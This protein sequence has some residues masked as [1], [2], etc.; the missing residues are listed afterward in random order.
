MLRNW[1]SNLTFT[2]PSRRLHSNHTN[3]MPVLRQIR[4]RHRSRFYS[5]TAEVL[6]DRALLTAFIVDTIEDGSLVGDGAVSLREAIV[7]A[8]TNATYLDAPAGDSGLDTITFHPSLNGLTIT[9]NGTGLTISEDLMISDG[10]LLPIQIDGDDASRVFEVAAGNVSL[11]DVTITG[12]NAIQ[13]AGLFVNSGQTLNLDNVM[14]TGNTATGAAATDGGGGIYNAG[15]TL[16]ISDS[17]I[18][19]NFATGTSGSGGGIFSTDGIVTLSN[20]TI[21]LNTANRAGGGIEL[22]EGSALL[23]S[24]NLINNDV[25]LATASPGNG[26]GVHITGAADFTMDGG[27]VFGN[28]AAREGGGLWNSTGT[29]TIQNGTLIQGNTAAGDAADDGG[30]GIFNNG[31]TLIIDGSAAPVQIVNNLAIGVLGSGGGIFNAVGGTA[32]IN[33]AIITGNEAERAGGGI[34]DAANMAGVTGLTLTDVTLDDNFAFGTDATSPGN[35]GGLHV[36]GAGDVKISGGTVSNNFAAAE[37]GGLWNG[38]GVMTISGGTLIDGNEAAGDLDFATVTTNLQGGG[39]IFNNG[40]MLTITDVGGAVTISGNAASGSNRGSGGGILSTGGDVSITGANIVGNEAVRA[41]GGIEIVTGM[42][43]LTNIDLSNN[44]VSAADLLSLGLTANPGNG[45]GL[46]VTGDATVSF[47]GGTVRNNVAANEGGGLWNSSDGTLLINGTEIAQNTAINGGG[48][49]VQGGTGATGTTS[50]T[51]TQILENIAT[52]DGA[53]QGGGGIFSEGTLVVADSILTSN[54]AMGTSGSGGGILNSGGTLNVSG[55][56][57][58]SNSASR[59][60]GALEDNAGMSTIVTSAFVFNAAGSAPGNGGAVHLT[61][62]AD[63]TVHNSTFSENSAVNEG[64]ALW[65]SAVGTLTVRNSTIVLN[66]VDG[67]SAGGGVFTVAGGETVLV[68][69]IVAGNSAG[70]ATANDIAGATVST[71]STNNLVGNAASSGGLTDGTSGNIVGN[72][73]LGTIMVSSVLNTVRGG[74]GAIP[75]FHVLVSGS[76]AV[77]AGTDLS[78]VGITTDQNGDARPQVGAFD[79]GAIESSLSVVNPVVTITQNVSVTEGQTAVFAI[80]LDRNPVTTVTVTV[81][82]TDTT[83]VAGEDYVAKTQTLTFLPGAALTQQFSVETIDDAVSEEIEFFVAQITDAVGA[84]IADATGTVQLLDN[85]SAGIP[86]L[87]AVEQFPGVRPTLTW[88]PV[89]GA[90]SYEVWLGRVFPASQRILASETAVTG[91]SYTPGVDLDPA[92]YRFW[93]RSVSSGGARSAWSVPIVF[94]VQPTVVSPVTPGFNSRPTFVWNPIPNTSGYELFIRTVDG[95]IIINDIQ[96]TFFTPTTDLPQGSIRW[97]I[98]SSDA[99]FNRG[100]SMGADFSGR[101]SVLTPTGTINTT[102]P[103]FTWLQVD[104]ASRY[105]VYVQNNATSEIIRDDNVQ[106]TSYS[107][108]APLAAGN[109]RVWVKAIGPTNSFDDGIWSPP[110]S[111]SIV[112]AAV[113]SNSLPEVDMLFSDL[114]DLLSQQA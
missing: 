9:L 16:N 33:D 58:R 86:V 3:L 97:W 114:G 1:L 113:E 12:G 10:N 104:N 17:T 14:V 41:G 45:G 53:A 30:G 91:T 87:D 8:N 109:Y 42:V 5:A 107:F 90:V 89:S 103:T 95:D 52:G 61:G 32:M 24:V 4:R 102:T 83:A 67:A 21:S 66:T 88:Q 94:E 101:T 57:F 38:S 84:S 62:A 71:T 46:H 43:T 56:S 48:V 19:A 70:T 111:F 40:G 51:D 49:Y 11:S 68:N 6:E 20:S 74:G 60:G 54:T 80:S 72:S 69:S 59:A 39:G 105:I 37:G 85:D 35:G 22:V 26:G 27:S 2:R 96:G 112:D 13:G 65:N 29:M 55:S 36:S 25:D 34:E 99:I 93:V 31:G 81:T 108:T 110:L 63:V 78:G 92:F 75:E 106:G 18:T 73:G 44:D 77:N 15:G 7:A 23:T 79:I 50:L 76:P 100:Y 64:G 47:L 82:T 98:R 28:R